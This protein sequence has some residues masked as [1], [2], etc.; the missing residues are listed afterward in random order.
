MAENKIRGRLGAIKMSVT[1]FAEKMGMSRPTAR[2]K[3]DGEV[4]FSAKEIKR[5]LEILDIPA[6]EAHIYFF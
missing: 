2:R 5:A 1:E 6:T 3:I 4:D